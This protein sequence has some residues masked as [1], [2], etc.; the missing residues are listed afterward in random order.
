[1]TDSSTAYRVYIWIASLRL[2]EKFWPSG[3][4]T[5]VDVFMQVYPKYALSGVAMAPHAHN[6]FLVV[7]VELGIAGFLALSQ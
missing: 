5:G 2:I 7:M 1:M 4:G 6:L 3:I